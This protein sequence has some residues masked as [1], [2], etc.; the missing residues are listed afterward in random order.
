MCSLAFAPMLSRWVERDDR[1]GGSTGISCS[2]HNSDDEPAPRTSLDSLAETTGPDLVGSI[3]VSSYSSS[4]YVSSY[5][6][7]HIYTRWSKYSGMKGRDR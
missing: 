7:S 2:D 5:S 6:L 4:I 3:Y 1:V